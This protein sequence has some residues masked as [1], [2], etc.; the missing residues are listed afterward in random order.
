MNDTPRQQ[1]NPDNLPVLAL[2]QLPMEQWQ[3]LTGRLVTSLDPAI[4]DQARL[5]LR[6]TQGSAT[7]TADDLLKQ[8]IEVVHVVLHPVSIETE[9]GELIQIT[10][11]VLIS[12]SGETAGFA[13]DGVIKSLQSLAS[14]YGPPPWNP[15]LRLKLVQVNTR[16]GRR[17][18]CLDV[19]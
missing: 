2:R 9:D 7:F 16:K 6:A 12:P 8:D 3:E 14:I 10:R 13:S 1:T 17:Y 11:S 5:L 19:L 18:Y 15:P 4:K